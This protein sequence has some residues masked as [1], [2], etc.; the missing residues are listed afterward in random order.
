[1]TMRRAT[2]WTFFLVCVGLFGLMAMTWAQQ[3]AQPQ[4]P[5]FA[6][7]TNIQDTYEAGGEYE[8]E[9]FIRLV[10]PNASVERGVLFLNVVENNAAKNYPHAAHRIFERATETVEIFRIPFD[11]DTLRAGLE[12]TVQVRIRPNAGVG[13]YSI[14][15]Q[16]FEGEQTDPNRV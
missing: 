13:S 12:T 1:M 9:L 5:A 10:D 8:I 16:L 14:V 6:I 2:S 11:G 15:F 7:E 4:E 3:E